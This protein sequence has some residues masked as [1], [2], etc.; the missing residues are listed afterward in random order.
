MVARGVDVFEAR[1]RSSCNKGAAVRH[2][3]RELPI[4]TLIVYFGDDVTDRDAFRELRQ[5]GISVEVGGGD[6]PLAD[7]TVSGPAAVV[8]LLKRIDDELK[9]R[10]TVKRIGRRP[11]RK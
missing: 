3:R 8:E 5:V 7:Y 10:K 4:G 6:S 2:I 11:K 9:K 1:L